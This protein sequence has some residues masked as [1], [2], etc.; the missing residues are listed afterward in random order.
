MR[1]KA[2]RRNDVTD[3]SLNVRRPEAP[4][5][6][7]LAGLGRLPPHG[8]RRAPTGRYRPR[9]AFRERQLTESGKKVPQLS[10]NIRL[11]RA[12][13]VVIGVL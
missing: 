12:P 11:I 5:D 13:Y 2:V 4:L 1:G 3:R 9:T 6:A 7:Q 10:Q 8:G